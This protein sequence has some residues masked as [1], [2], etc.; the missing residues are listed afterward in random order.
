MRM[1][2]QSNS[3]LWLALNLPQRNFLQSFQQNFLRSFP[4]QK[5]HPGTM[6]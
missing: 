5:P 6:P 2:T 4:T 1:P 3:W